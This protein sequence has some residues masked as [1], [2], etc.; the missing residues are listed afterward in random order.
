R[1]HVRC[2]LRVRRRGR[3]RVRHH[4][5]LMADNFKVEVRGYK[6]LIRASALADKATKREM[7]ATFRKVGDP[8]KQDAAALFQRYDA[9]SAAG[10]KT[11]VRQRGISVEQSL[12]KTTGKHP[13]F[14]RLQ[15]RKALL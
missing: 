12:R 1:R 15:M 8:V 2:D 10:Y 3:A 6:E 13:E 14:G 9:G 7:R 5:H 4:R 11:R